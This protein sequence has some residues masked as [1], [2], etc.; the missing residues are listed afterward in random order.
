MSPVRVGLELPGVLLGP[1][2]CRVTRR[3]R[4]HVWIFHGAPPWKIC[5]RCSRTIES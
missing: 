4:P 2:V 5:L 1:L 3:H